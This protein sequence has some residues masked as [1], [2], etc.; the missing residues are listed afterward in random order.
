MYRFLT[1]V[2]QNRDSYI[3]FLK[4][5]YLLKLFIS[6][7]VGR[8]I[9]EQPSNNI[10]LWQW[11]LFQSLCNY[12][13][14]TNAKE[15]IGCLNQYFQSQ[16]L[17]SKPKVIISDRGKAFTSREFGSFVKI[18]DIKHIKVATGSSQ[19]KRV[20]RCNDYPNVVQDNR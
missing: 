3:L 1:G 2:R 12:T 4:A 11:M 13:K 5:S 15:A 8:L 14:T 20:N 16:C 6:T 19:V 10:Y 9:S 7:I 18:Q 17:H